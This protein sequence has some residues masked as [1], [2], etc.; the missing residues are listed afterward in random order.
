VPCG[1]AT[2]AEYQGLPI[3]FQVLGRHFDESTIFRVART[4]ESLTASTK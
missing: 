2:S 1:T 4:V 3:G